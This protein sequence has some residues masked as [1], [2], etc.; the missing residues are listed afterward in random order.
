MRQALDD[1]GQ[2]HQSGDERTCGFPVLP[3]KYGNLT[4]T[5]PRESPGRYEF[6]IFTEKSGNAFALIYKEKGTQ[7]AVQAG[8]DQPATKPADKVPAKVQPPTPTSKD[9]PR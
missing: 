7:D 8:A 1:I 9:G 3:D 4:F 5:A 6:R 2:G